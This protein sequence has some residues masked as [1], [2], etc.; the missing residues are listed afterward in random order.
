MLKVKSF[1]AAPF[2]DMTAAGL[3]NNQIGYAASGF[4]GIN[5]G[6]TSDYSDLGAL[7]ERLTAE[8]SGNFE[9]VGAST[10]SA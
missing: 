4:A 10:R 1:R 2:F 9:R 8:F 6:G 5:S 3:G 7:L